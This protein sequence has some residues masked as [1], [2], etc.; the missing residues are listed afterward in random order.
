MPRLT[1]VQC[2]PVQAFGKRH[3]EDVMPEVNTTESVANWCTVDTRTGTLSCVLEE[4]YCFNAEI[5][6]DEL[7]LDDA[8]DFRDDQRSRFH[9]HDPQCSL[10]RVGTH[11][12]SFT[13]SHTVNLG[14]WILR[15]LFDK[16]IQ[17]EAKRDV[18]FRE[19]RLFFK[20]FPSESET[21]FWDMLP[22]YKLKHT[23]SWLW[24]PFGELSALLRTDI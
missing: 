8:N 10:I 7:G 9:L 11:K 3:L 4:N 1:N 18:A 13:D 15:F 12:G 19:V 24:L 17:V 14:K 21:C 22:F 20:L 16:L 23:C 2:V 6:A 5:Y